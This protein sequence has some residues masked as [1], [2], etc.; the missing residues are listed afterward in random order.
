MHTYTSDMADAV[1]ENQM[2]VIKIALAEQ[3]KKI[4]NESYENRNS[5]LPFIQKYKS[6]AFYRF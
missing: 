5:D 4:S 3:E 6:S 1:R 2:S